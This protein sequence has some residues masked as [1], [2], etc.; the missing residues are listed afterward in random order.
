MLVQRYIFLVVLLLVSS[1]SSAKQVTVPDFDRDQAY[2]I[3]QAA[4]GRTVGFHQFQ[5]PDGELISLDDLRG[6]PLVI[7]LIYTSCY[8]ICPTTTQHLRKVVN[9]ARAALGTENF[10]VVT[11]G[12][13]TFRDTPQMMQ[14]FAD[15]QQISE[16]NWFFLSG[17]QETIDSLTK[18]LGFIYYPTA[19]GFDHLIQATVLDAAGEVYLQV[20]GMKFDTPLLV[21]P[22]KR[23]ALN[24]QGAGFFTALTNQVKL[25][26]TIYDPAQD[27]YRIDYSIFIGTFIGLLCVGVLGFQLVKEWR[28]TLNQGE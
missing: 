24:D 17:D 3:S 27:K 18:Q 26:C 19:N 15:R 13:D 23:L 11:I 12:F 7:S 8:H 9:K 16:A 2:S 10:N 21:E 4:I 6:K 25:F 14:F 5:K 22:L 28:F 20:Y 1:V